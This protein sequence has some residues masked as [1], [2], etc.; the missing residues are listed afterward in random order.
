[1]LGVVIGATPSTTV[2]VTVAALD[3]PPYTVLAKVLQ[4][5]KT[6]YAYW[7]AALR[8]HAAGGDVT[9][10]AQCASCGKGEGKVAV[11][12]GVTFGDVWLCS[13]Q[14]NMELPMVHEHG[15]NASYHAVMAGRYSKVRL[16]EMGKN[17]LRDDSFAT[18]AQDHFVIAPA[19][20]RGQGNLQDGALSTWQLPSVGRFANYSCRQGLAGLPRP[21]VN[22]V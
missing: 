10:S 16:F 11:V 7:R 3:E 19:A 18:K 5:K 14:S 20:G 6:G 12:K 9:I 8:P 2:N 4:T 22:E 13:G 1:V 15:R 21:K 17:K